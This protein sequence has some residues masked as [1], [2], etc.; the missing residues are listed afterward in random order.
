MIASFSRLV[1]DHVAKDPKFT[2]ALL[3]EGIETMLKGELDVGKGVLRDYIKGSIGF[4]RLGAEIG[5]Q[6]KSLIRM[7]GPRGNPQARNLFK[8]IEFL[9]EHAG[10]EVE[11]VSRARR[12]RPIAKR[13]TRSPGQ[14]SPSRTKVPL[15]EAV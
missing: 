5:M 1:Q 4:E 13:W 14:T 15:R 8:V 6:P 7:L 3:R 9:L 10:I 2:D 12:S 11:V